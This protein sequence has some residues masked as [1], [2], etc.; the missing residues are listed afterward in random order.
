MSQSESGKVVHCVK[1]HFQYAMFCLLVL[2]C[3]G[4]KLEEEKI[5]QVEDGQRR[6]LLSFNR[7][8]MLNFWPSLTRILFYKRW[9]EFLQIRRDQE[10]V[11]IPLIRARKNARIENLS[12]DKD[13]KFGKEEFIVSYVDTLL[14]LQLPHEN[15]KLEEGE[16]VSLCSEFLDGGTDTTSTALQWIFANLVKYPH[17][18]E[19]LFMEI[20][21]VVGEEQEVK[22]DHLHR[23]PYLKAVILEGLRRHPP[24]HFVLPHAVTQ[25][26]VLDGFVVPKNGTI[27]FM[28]AEMGRDP[29]VWEDPMAFNPERFLNTEGG[30][31]FDVTGSREI[32]MMPFGVGRRICPGYGLAML[33]LEYFVANLVWNFKWMA[34][35]GD[36][37][38][39]SEKQE[40]TVV[41][42][43]PLKAQIS[44]R[45]KPQN[46]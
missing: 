20:K 26:T 4:D 22:D 25:D 31:A 23:M 40:F 9:D 14:D 35:D 1:D 10:K 34:A 13:D 38:D 46:F 21:D 11:L 45:L 18:Q 16:I 36:E 32:K 19:K 2:M 15:R 39:L 28:V 41:M 24:G 43:N 3:F 5:K 33:H 30:E 6:M 27:N 7:F 37:V 8:S 17:I 44:P 12:K 29:N 42:K